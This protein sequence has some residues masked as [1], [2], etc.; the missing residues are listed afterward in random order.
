MGEG[1]SGRNRSIFHFRLSS[2]LGLGLDLGLIFGL[3][4]TVF[5]KALEVVLDRHSTPI[6]LLE[7]SRWG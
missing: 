4:K 5:A 2:S 3:S 1:W 6:M 7:T